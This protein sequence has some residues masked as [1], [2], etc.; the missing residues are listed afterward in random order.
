MP[1]YCFIQGCPNHYRGKKALDA[2]TN[3]TNPKKSRLFYQ[4]Q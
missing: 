2:S 4:W 1:E 3:V